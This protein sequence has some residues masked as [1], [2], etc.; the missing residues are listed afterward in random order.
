MFN[1]RYEQPVPRNGWAFLRSAL[2]IGGLGF[3]ALSLGLACLDYAGEPRNE[4]ETYS[5]IGSGSA[6]A[7]DAPDC[8]TALPSAT[9]GGSG[10]GSGS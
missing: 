10:S 7:D 8:G 1:K 3:C 6:E 5:P 9:T 4:C 2:V